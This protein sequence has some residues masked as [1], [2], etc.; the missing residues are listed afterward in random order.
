MLIFIFLIYSCLDYI[1]NKTFPINIDILLILGLEQLPQKASKYKQC[2]SSD[3]E[4]A[5]HSLYYGFSKFNW[6]LEHQK[7]MFILHF[8]LFNHLNMVL[9][10]AKR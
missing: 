3:M 5:Q 10:V 7:N 8:M 4:V 9:F 1:C 2:I 6:N